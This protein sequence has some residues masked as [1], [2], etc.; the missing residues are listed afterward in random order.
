MYINPVLNESVVA[1]I[2]TVPAAAPSGG[3]RFALSRNRRQSPAKIRTGDT[4]ETVSFSSVKRNIL[5][6]FVL[7]SSSF[8]AAWSFIGGQS[9]QIQLIASGVL[10]CLLLLASQFALH[11]PEGA[12]VLAPIFVIFEGLFFGALVYLCFPNMSE[13]LLNFLGISFSALLAL[14]LFTN[15]TLLASKHHWTNVGM[16][17]ILGIGVWYL[18]IIAM[19]YLLHVPM[20]LPHT[21][22]LTIF[23]CSLVGVVLATRAFVEDLDY[24]RYCIEY[25]APKYMEWYLPFAIMVTVPVWYLSC[26][27]RAVIED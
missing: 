24:V 21:Y 18:Y 20:S 5:L 10:L 2:V 1:K 11:N 6:L 19:E 13:M 26:G 7:F 4:S 9:I 23:V 15:R 3:A 27:L 14:L 25:G 8:Y 16:G 12:S 22:E 17:S